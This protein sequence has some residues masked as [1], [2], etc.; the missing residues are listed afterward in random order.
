MRGGQRSLNEI[1]DNIYPI[2]SIYL[3][4]VSTNPSNYFG[5]VWERITGKFLLA[6]DDS[7]YFLGATGGSAKKNIQIANLPG[8]AV[9]RINSAYQT[10]GSNYISNPAGWTTAALDDIPDASKN[11]AFDIIPPYLAVYVWKRIS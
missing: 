11:Q 9:V 7:S 5:G 4:T 10:Y 6:A 1:L 8:R 2:G 3:S